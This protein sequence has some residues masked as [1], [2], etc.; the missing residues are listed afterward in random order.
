MAK[1]P[2]GKRIT[3][4]DL[5]SS[6]YPNV[7]R[8]VQHSDGKTGI[9]IEDGFQFEVTSPDA[10]EGIQAAQSAA[11]NAAH[12]AE[13]A[14][15]TA[16][17]K[18]QTYYGMNDPPTQA[19]NNGDYYVNTT[20]KKEWVC[21]DGAWVLS[22]SGAV[23]TEI[24]GGVRHHSFNAAGVN[25]TPAT[26]F[27]VAVRVN[28]VAVTPT[29]IAWTS[30]GF[31]SGSGAAATFTPTVG[32]FSTSA[33][34]VKCVVVVDGVSYT[35]YAV[36]AGSQTGATGSPGADGAAGADG[37]GYNGLT[38]TTSVAIATGDKTF[39]V[40]QDASVNAYTVGSRVRVAYTAAPAT[41]WMEGVIKMYSGTS[42]VV[43]VDVI[44]TAGT[45]AAWTISLAGSRGATGIPGAQGASSLGVGA[46]PD[47]SAFSTVGGGYV[48]IHGFTTE[49]VAS[50]TNG[51]VYLDAA[52]LPVTK[53]AVYPGLCLQGLILLPIAGGTPIAG[54]YRISSDSFYTMASGVATGLSE[55]NYV[56]IGTIEM[57]SATDV[58]AVSFF[59][60]AKRLSEIRSAFASRYIGIAGAVP[61]SGTK[62][63]PLYSVVEASPSFTFSTTTTTRIAKPGDC[64]FVRGGTD[65]TGASDSVKALYVFDGYYWSIPRSDLSSTYKALAITGLAAVTRVYG[66]VGVA[67]PVEAGAVFDVL[68][69]NVGFI[70]ALATILQKSAA[71]CDD[72]VTPRATFDW[73]NAILTLLSADQKTKMEVSD[74][75]VKA[76]KD[77][78]VQ[79]RYVRLTDESLDWVD[80]PDTTPPSSE[81]LQ[82]RIGRLGVGG[83][84]I[85]D[86]GFC[87]PVTRPWGAESVVEAAGGMYPTYI[88]LASGELRIAYKQQST[89]YLIERVWNGSSWGEA[90]QIAGTVRN[91]SYFQRSNGE[92]RIIYRRMFAPYICERVWNGTSWGAEITVNAEN[93]D[94]PV[95]ME[96]TPGELVVAYQRTAD[97]YVVSR[98]LDG[99]MW[100]SESLIN[101]ADSAY[102]TAIR[103]QDGSIR[104]AYMRQ[105]DGNMV[106][107][108]WDGD[109]WSGESIIAPGSNPKYVQRLNGEIRIVY[110]TGAYN[111]VAERIW[112]GSSWS[113]ESIISSQGCVNPMAIQLNNG[114]MRLAYERYDTGAIIE[115][116]MTPYATIGSGVVEHGLDASGNEYLVLG[117]GTT[118]YVAAI[119]AALGSG[120][121]AKLAAAY[122]GA[123]QALDTTS[124]PT[125]AGLTLNGAL[126]PASSAT[127]SQSIAKSGSWTV[128]RGVYMFGVTQSFFNI[129]VRVG[130]T[131]YSSWD[132]GGAVISD[133]SNLRI[134]N[135]D[136]ESAYTTYYR[137][138]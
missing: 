110:K 97:G 40:N 19:A 137:K 120:W 94:Y 131:W 80:A 98:T 39:A 48:Y 8:Y 36:V 54:I 106:E 13:T 78:G 55:A 91:I 67:Q 5:E 34:F 66:Y 12:V 42:M 29:S 56:A 90:T 93:S 41:N 27:T 65:T 7:F 47:Y 125:F 37:L 16:N 63:V 4:R 79:R 124:S 89:S 87:A 32:A 26:A 64:V 112:Y 30:G 99:S 134:I 17:A 107:R 2:V 138:F 102:V 76:F 127:G 20:T 117:D 88:Q 1:I 59:P 83:P 121:A 43:T 84:V 31:L 18:S 6:Q 119:K 11:D 61:A 130:S 28:G 128:P 114:Q 82:A 96:P 69:A 105:A 136:T 22:N 21:V 109:S 60:R 15:Q 86:G 81:I 133:G 111:Y 3:S 74:A 9:L 95:Y 100:G 85:I 77:R 101:P 45:F 52:Q 115:R 10:L 118:L 103:L 72:T 62:S 38:S 116:I 135:I 14:Q 70:G 57:S 71:T 35:E 129:Q 49:G 58:E 68:V 25:Q 108:T 104:L 46:K 75:S 132:A 24:T 73:N 50:D 113:D 126:L 51:F 23:K 44:G 33:T 53:A 123:N 122:S 92:L